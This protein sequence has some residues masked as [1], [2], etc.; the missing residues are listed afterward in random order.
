MSMAGVSPG[1]AKSNI[2]Q[3]LELVGLGYLGKNFTKTTDNWV[4]WIGLLILVV[5][6]SPYLY[7]YLLR[8]LFK[9]FSVFFSS[10]KKRML[11]ELYPNIV[12]LIDILKEEEFT[13]YDPES[14]DAGFED[15]GRDKS[16]LA[17][18]FFPKATSL[19]HK[20]E[21]LNILSPDIEPVSFL[22]RRK[23]FCFLVKLAPLAEDG[24]LMEAQELHSPKSNKREE[25]KFDSNESSGREKEI[26][27]AMISGPYETLGKHIA[28]IMVVEDGVE[29]ALTF[30]LKRW[31]EKV[32]SLQRGDLIHAVGLI[33][34]V[35]DASHPNVINLI[36]CRFIE[37]E[38]K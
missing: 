4:F 10:R 2:T 20:L 27:G 24:N 1:D 23:W 8:H 38:R 37:Y 7:R 36:E 19:A 29:Y 34:S 32:Y 17:K 31:Y 3:W 35:A 22:S 30:N 11:R 33:E 9:L 16:D 28:T 13:P 6:V 25:D 26:K 18:D 14:Q 21:K 5:W 12:E 15:G